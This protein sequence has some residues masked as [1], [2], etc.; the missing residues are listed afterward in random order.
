MKRTI[1]VSSLKLDVDSTVSMALFL[2]LTTTAPVMAKP[3]LPD[4]FNRQA[5]A[6]V[7]DLAS[8]AYQISETQD[9]HHPLWYD[10]DTE[11]VCFFETGGKGFGKFKVYD[12]HTGKSGNGFTRAGSATRVVW[13]THKAAVKDPALAAILEEIVDWVDNMDSREAEYK[14]GPKEIL[15]DFLAP[16]ALEKVGH[17]RVKIHT[18]HI[19]VLSFLPKHIGS[20]GRQLSNAPNSAAQAKILRDLINDVLVAIGD[21]TSHALRNRAE[22]DRDWQALAGKMTITPLNPL[23]DLVLV[24]DSPLHI[25]SLRYR[26]NQRYGESEDNLKKYYLLVATFANSKNLRVHKAFPS[27]LAELDLEELRDKFIKRFNLFKDYTRLEGENTALSLNN[28]KDNPKILEEVFSYCREHFYMKVSAE[29]VTNF[30]DLVDKMAEFLVLSNNG[31][32]SNEILSDLL[33]RLEKYSKNNAAGVAK[34][35]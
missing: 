10:E 5:N 11:A 27:G 18:N 1:C 20:K 7:F 28:V 2:M 3:T 30:I 35:S 13:E 26:L 6:I 34:D 33:Q 23:V 31:S 17:R 4:I 22:A 24:E 8:P 16:L 21:Y 29:L 25:A 14:Q 15:Y 12:H 9:D 32:A 19:H